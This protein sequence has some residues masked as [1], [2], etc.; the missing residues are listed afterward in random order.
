VGTVDQGK[1]KACFLMTLSRCGFEFLQNYDACSCWWLLTIFAFISVIVAVFAQ[2]MDWAKP[3]LANSRLTF[4]AAEH[5]NLW[6]RVLIDSN[7]VIESHSSSTLPW[8]PFAVEYLACA[9][10]TREL[11]SLI[12]I[13]V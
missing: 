2:A 8:S 6:A 10:V 1:R 3:F 7:S 9:F 5:C 4:G 12:I 13:T 11:L